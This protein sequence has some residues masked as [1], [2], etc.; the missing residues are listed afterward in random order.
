M[1]RTAGA[2]QEQ[3]RC[4]PAGF[5]E[6]PSIQVYQLNNLAGLSTQSV[7]SSRTP[8]DMIRFIAS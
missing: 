4:V 5:F 6:I 1:N 8:V 3:F 2:S 7:D